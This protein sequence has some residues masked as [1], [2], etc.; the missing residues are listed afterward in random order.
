ML[1]TNIRFPPRSSSMP[2]TVDA[3]TKEAHPNE[4]ENTLDSITDSAGK[5]NWEKL[6][7]MILSTC[8]PRDSKKSIVSEFG[9]VDFFRFST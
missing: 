2:L 3:Q 7:A 4:V 1:M 9:I 5:I 6:T 8:N